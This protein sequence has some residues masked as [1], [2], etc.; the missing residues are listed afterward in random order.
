MKPSVQRII[1]KL[2]K[3]QEKKVE[4][5]ELASMR[6]VEQLYKELDNLMSDTERFSAE[7]RNAGVLGEKTATNALNVSKE[8]KREIESVKSAADELGVKI[9]IDGYEAGV[10]SM[11]KALERYKEGYSMV[12]RFTAS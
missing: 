6:K 8:V 9:D 11:T 5:V 2:A 1:T 12:K 7:V 10:A 4:K 3:E